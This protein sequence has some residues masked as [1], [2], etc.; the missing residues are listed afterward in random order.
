MGLMFLRGGSARFW[1]DRK[2]GEI[3]VRTATAE[4]RIHLEQVMANDFHL[5]ELARQARER[6]SEPA[7]G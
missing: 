4:R 6:M 5:A 2:F 1:A 7:R 3:I